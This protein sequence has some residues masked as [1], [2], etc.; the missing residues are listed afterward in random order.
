MQSLEHQMRDFIHKSVTN[1]YISF[2]YAQ[3]KQNQ[4]LEELLL[5]FALYFDNA[6]KS[7]FHVTKE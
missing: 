4:E 7:P 6:S 3:A 5:C 1:W 2:S